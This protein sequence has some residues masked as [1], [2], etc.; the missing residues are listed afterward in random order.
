MLNCLCLRVDDCSHSSYT[1]LHPKHFLSMDTEGLSRTRPLRAP[2]S[3]PPDG[4]EA[5]FQSRVWS[6][7]VRVQGF[8]FER[9]GFRV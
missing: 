4:A 1:S 9:L 2:S 5:A 7:L 3:P 8:F 6:F